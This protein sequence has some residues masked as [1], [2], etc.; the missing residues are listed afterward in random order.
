MVSKRIALVAASVGIIAAAL[1]TGAPVAAAP[2][3]S[4]VTNPSAI[5]LTSHSA[6][7]TSSTHQAL[8]VTVGGANFG[9]GSPAASP[10]EINIKLGLPAKH[11]SHTWVFQ[12]APG[13]FTDNVPMSTGAIDTGTTQVAPFG[14]ISVSFASSGHVSTTLT[15]GKTSVVTQPLTIHVALFFDTNSTGT[16]SWGQLG[17]AVHLVTYDRHGSLRTQYG[18]APCPPIARFDP[19]QTNVAWNA[20]HGMS[21]FTTLSGGWTLSHG[22]KRGQIVG[23][24]QVLLT[25]PSEAYRYDSV[26]AKA[27]VPTLTVSH[28]KPTLLVTTSGTVATGSARLTSSHARKPQKLRCTK[29]HS[30][31]HHEKQT[32]W[33]TASF[34]NGPVPLRLHEQIEGRISVPN[35]ASATIDRN[36]EIN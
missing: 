13:S 2:R 11:E 9:G 30:S 32:F 27:P 15:C 12:L 8:H 24:R 28:G 21:A 1:G 34:K 36:T 14:Q 4:D 31:A 25:S 19:C 33:V 3:V 6:V 5:E 17:T 7:I 22:T 20:D 10:A 23:S 18:G 16:H 35:S 29:A 26:T